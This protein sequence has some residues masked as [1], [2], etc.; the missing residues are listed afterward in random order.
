MTA[1]DDWAGFHFRGCPVSQ[2]EQHC[3]QP[4]C[5]QQMWLWI[6]LSSQL[7]RKQVSETH[8]PILP[9][10][11][12]TV[13]ISCWEE[14]RISWRENKLMFC[15]LRYYIT[16]ISKML[17]TSCFPNTSS[18]FEI[19]TMAMLRPCGHWLSFLTY[20]ILFCHCLRYEL[21]SLAVW[22]MGAFKS[23]D[24]LKASFL[25][26]LDCGSELNCMQ[27]SPRAK[28]QSCPHLGP[29]LQD[30][31]ALLSGSF[32]LSGHSLH[33]SFLQALL[34]QKIWGKSRI[35]CICSWGELNLI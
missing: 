1:L 9:Q 22:D 6:W 3:W 34:V 33:F 32:P 14:N 18:H 13:H 25:P 5:L 8:L 28:R 17:E 20:F 30:P 35:S 11:V 26:L 10:L 27:P 7:S 12:C 24:C 23:S 2:A 31:F 16:L 19:Y 29:W 21:G 15:S 4:Y